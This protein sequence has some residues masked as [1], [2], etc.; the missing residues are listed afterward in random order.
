MPRTGQVIQFGISSGINSGQ[1]VFGGEN[2]LALM[3]SRLMLEKALLTSV[4]VNG[5]SI[6]LADFFIDI[7]ELREEWTKKNLP[8]KKIRF[9][10]NSKF[11]DL[12]LMQ[13]GLISSFHQAIITEYL[14]IEKQDKK[15]SIIS[16]KVKSKNELF[17][18]YLAE[19]LA[20]EVSQFY[21][22]TK[23]KKSVENL[24]ILN[25]QADSIKR[26]LNISM[27]GS[28]ISS[29]STPNISSF[30]QVLR[31]P[32]QRKQVDAQLNQAILTQLVQNIELAK[33]TLRTETPLIQVIDR[34]VLPLKVEVPNTFLYMILG[35]TLSVITTAFILIIRKLLVDFS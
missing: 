6:T 3:K 8:L 1:G 14:I 5:K 11:Q 35:F 24:R 18:K 34:P 9:D 25:L 32:S 29:D 31:V 27:L 22:E 28:A 10:I 23:T 12:T 4:I 21:V 13:N 15:S 19:I 7:N 20:K 2:F 30:K 26:A 16:L 33:L 17:S